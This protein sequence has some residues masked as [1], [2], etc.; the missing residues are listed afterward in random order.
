MDAVK[1]TFAWI[2]A[3]FL[4]LIGLAIVFQMFTGKI[5]L[6]KL[7]A[8]DDGKGSMSRLQLLIFTFVIAGSL[9]L[10]IVSSVPPAFP[11]T[12][13][14]EVLALLGISGGS[15]VL[16]KGIQATKDAQQGPPVPPKPPS[17]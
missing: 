14:P 8:E 2:I 16:S 10:I 4:G 13:P 17:P 9:F 7:I 6:Q 3:V 12:I 11:A 1:E 15:Y 5:D